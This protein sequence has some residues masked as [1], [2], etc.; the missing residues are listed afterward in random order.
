MTLLRAIWGLPPAGATQ[1]QKPTSRLLFQGE[2]RWQPCAHTLQR[3]ADRS[4]WLSLWPPLASGK[5]WRP[6]LSGKRARQL[7]LK[8]CWRPDLYDVASF[9]QL[10]CSDYRASQGGKAFGDGIPGRKVLSLQQ[11]L[12]LDCSNRRCSVLKQLNQAHE[13]T[14]KQTAPLG[15]VGLSALSQTLPLCRGVRRRRAPISAPPTLR[16]WSPALVPHQGSAPSHV[17]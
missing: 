7:A 4:P 6:L 14:P 11:V 13:T 10:A 1:Q 2:G 8:R 3:G 16:T 17:R 15:A 5:S 12:A 9:N